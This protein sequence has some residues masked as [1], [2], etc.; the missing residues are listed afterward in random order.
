MQVACQGFEPIIWLLQF[1]DLIRVDLTMGSVTCIQHQQCRRLHEGNQAYHTC[2]KE[3]Y[4][5]SLLHPLVQSFEQCTTQQVLDVV[6][7][8]I[9]DRDALAMSTKQAQSPI[10]GSA[11]HTPF[12]WIAT[13]IYSHSSKPRSARERL[14]SCTGPGMLTESLTHPFTAPQTAELRKPVGA[15]GRSAGTSGI[16]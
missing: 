1:A 4:W 12:K 8:G 13:S 9:C 10:S 15:H 11:P 14:A 16:Y 6:G 3:V 2:W 5:A 7:L